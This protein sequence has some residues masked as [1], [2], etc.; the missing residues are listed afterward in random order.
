MQPPLEPQ[1]VARLMGEYRAGSNDA[2]SQLVQIL[3]PELRRLAA[4]RMKGERADHTWQPTVLVNELYLELVKIKGLHAGNLDEG[5]RAAFLDL[6]AQIM[7][8]L[9]IHHAR[10]LYRGIHKVPTDILTNA[11]QTDRE[12]LLLAEN[13]MERLATIDPKLR[14]VVEM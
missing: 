3:Y 14:S 7:K 2:A 13:L 6:A 11:G 8:R 4:A 12:D 1:T 10:P 5:G 9:L